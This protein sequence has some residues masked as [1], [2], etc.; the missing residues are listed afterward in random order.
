MNM[1]RNRLIMN[2]E[3]TFPEGKVSRLEAEYD[4]IVIKGREENQKTQGRRFP[5]QPLFYVEGIWL[6]SSRV[7]LIRSSP[8]AI[9]STWISCT[10]AAMSIIP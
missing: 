6:Q 1:E 8:S 10:K 3:T 7:S 9:T 5:K 4:K 2:G